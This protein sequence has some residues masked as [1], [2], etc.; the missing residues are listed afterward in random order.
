MADSTVFAI[1]DQ[2]TSK[3]F[4][5]W[6]NPADHF[7]ILRTFSGSASYVTG[8][9]SLKLGASMSN[10]T[11][12]TVVRYTGDLTERF[13][14]GVPN[15]VT[16]RLP[17]DQR[18]GIKRDLGIFAQDRWTVRRATV[19]LGL[20]Y[21]NF[22]GQILDEDLPASR[23]LGP[24]CILPGCTT[25]I[26]HI[27]GFDVQDWKDLSPRFSIAYDLFGDGKTAVK[28]SFGRYLQGEAAST[29]AANNPETTVGRT[30]AR[31]WHDDDGNL[32]IFNSDG[33]L[34]VSELGPT[35]NANFG[36]FVTSNA[37]SDPKL[38]NGWGVR[39]YSWE[40]QAGVQH[41]LTPQISATADYYYRW[42]GNQTAVDNL[43]V[44][45]SNYDGP[46]C[47]TAP[48]DAS[49]PGGGGFEACGLYD[50]NRNSRSLAAQNYTTFA[51]NLGG[52]YSHRSGIDVSGMARFARG[53]F[54]QAGINME[55]LVTD[56]CA[57]GSVDSPE[58]RFCHTLQPFRPDAKI[59]G[60][61]AL[62]W[63]QIILTG[64]YQFSRGPA[65]RA[66]WSAPN[67]L[68]APIIGRNLSACAA[69]TGACTSTKSIELIEPNTAYGEN[70]NQL[71]I[72]GSKRFTVGGRLRLRLDLDLYN[73]FN[74]DW[75]YTVSST[76]STAASS[77]WLRPTNVLQSR[78]FKIGGQIDF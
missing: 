20:R 70:L 8:S 53:T 63:Q 11:R 62:P 77:A 2:V 51:D 74:S 66:T 32:S 19:N 36:Q 21:D 25:S 34:Q 26:P 3:W 58:N 60:S 55:R 13:S 29:A 7:S 23:W 52:R 15:Q 43:A 16:L 9:H 71:D 18:E 22:V 45:N 57:T 42:L 24:S 49:L 68:I 30:D 50:L 59:L 17:L 69:A 14:S 40:Y 28:S 39:Q 5:A 64:T 73:L 6:N 48:V 4:N 35:S 78:M 41:Q 72:R 31:N 54:L 47:V 76:F 75:P 46:F 38:L 12:R 1:Q 56:T 44:D 67:S 27:D 61:Y 37:T 10:G 65:L 33:S